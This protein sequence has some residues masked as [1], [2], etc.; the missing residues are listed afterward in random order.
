L[1]RRVIEAVDILSELDAHNFDVPDEECKLES[2]NRD[3]A[4][5]TAGREW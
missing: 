1:H 2:V 3:V 4:T 5:T